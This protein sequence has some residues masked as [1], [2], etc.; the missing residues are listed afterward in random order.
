SAARALAALL[1]CVACGSTNTAEEGPAQDVTS[2]CKVPAGYPQTFQATPERTREVEDELTKLRADVSDAEASV[3]PLTGGIDFFSGKVALSLDGKGAF[4]DQAQRAFI[5][6]AGKG[7]ALE[8]LFRLDG[9]GL[10]NG[11]CVDLGPG[12]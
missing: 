5:A 1:S 11:G 2:A 3:D 4:C 8:R 12:S 10:E 6:V 9:S 7:A